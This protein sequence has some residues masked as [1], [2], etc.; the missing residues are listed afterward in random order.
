M[1]TERSAAKE[2]A[3]DIYFGQLVII[4]ARWF[5][6]VAMITLALWSS[7]TVGQ[8]ILAVLFIVP[9]MAINF[10]VHGR[11]LMDKPV[12]ALLLLL[13]SIV[14]VVIITLIV[15]FWQDGRGMASQFYIFYYPMLLAFAFVF[16]ARN[17]GIYTIVTLAAYLVACLVA[18]P[19]LI[20]DS[21]EMERVAIRLI[22]MATMGALGIYYWR[23]QRNRRRAE[24]MPEMEP[25]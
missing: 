20:A 5:V 25:A 12:N 7:K 8:L 11:Y 21:A 16:P 19:S 13:L 15:L 24:V 22:T 1:R 9:M 14:D 3:E 10:F 4:Y 17:S 23:I 2:A 18:T 6:I